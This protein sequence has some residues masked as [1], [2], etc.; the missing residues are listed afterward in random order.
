MISFEMPQANQNYFRRIY[1]TAELTSSITLVEETVRERGEG[2]E[3]YELDGRRF[4]VRL[5]YF[6][7]LI[8]N[9]A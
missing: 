6:D 9:S 2:A 5:L 4:V 3:T 8:H 7:T 1:E